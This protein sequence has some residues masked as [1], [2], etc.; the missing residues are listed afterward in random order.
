[1]PTEFLQPF[2]AI[3]GGHLSRVRHPDDHCQVVGRVHRF[4]AAD[5]VDFQLEV[6]GHQLAD[7]DPFV[8][9][10]GQHALA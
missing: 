1:M 2:R 10:C 8:E 9:K 5:R 4:L 7:K 3:W 6:L